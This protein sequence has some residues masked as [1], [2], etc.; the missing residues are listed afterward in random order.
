MSKVTVKIVTTS[1]SLPSNVKAGKLRISLSQGTDVVDYKD[2]DG[3]EAVF[4]AVVDGEY[5]VTAQRL[6]DTGQALGGVVTYDFTVNDESDDM[7]DAPSAIS[8]TVTAD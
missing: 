7:Y 3:K 8:V 4:E 5:T 6:D 2:V 1:V